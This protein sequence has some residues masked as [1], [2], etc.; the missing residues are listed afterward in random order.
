MRNRAA[1]TILTLAFAFALAV[2]GTSVFADQVAIGGTHSKDEIKNACNAV[3]GDLLGVSDSG[4]YGCENPSKGTLVLC[5]KDGKCTGWVPAKTRAARNR[6]VKTL[7]LRVNTAAGARCCTGVDIGTSCVA[8]PKS[9]GCPADH[10]IRVIE[11]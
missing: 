11:P 8:E 5:N 3:G 4:S 10:P 2:I 6:V 1:T 7:G 9:G